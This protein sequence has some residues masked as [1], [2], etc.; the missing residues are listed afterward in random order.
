M[1]NFIA[2]EEIL[3]DNNKNNSKLNNDLSYD[4]IDNEIDMKL[5]Y[6]S[7]IEKFFQV[8]LATIQ[9]SDT[10]GI[11]E[12]I[13]S[14]LPESFRIFLLRPNA[15][16]VNEA[17]ESTERGFG[18]IL[19]IFR[20]DFQ[21]IF[22]GTL[23]CGSG[24]SARKNDDIGVFS[25]T[26]IC[27]RQHDSCPYSIQ[28]GESMGSLKNIGI[29]TRSACSCDYEFYKCL[30]KVNTL[31][32]TNIGTTYFNILRPQC[33]GFHYPI[34]ACEKYDRIQVLLDKLSTVNYYSNEA[35]YERV[36]T[37]YAWQGLLHH[38]AYQS[39]G[40]IAV[41]C[42]GATPI[43]D[44]IAGNTRRLP[45]EAWYPY[46]TKKSPAFEITSGHQAI[47]VIIA[48]FHNIAMDTLITGL[49][50]AAC[51]QLEIIKQNLKN[52]DLNFSDYCVVEKNEKDLLNKQINRI[53]EHSNE[54]Y[55]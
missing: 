26:D 33:F 50:N 13:V 38:A 2:S 10:N 43:A 7:R 48:C 55:K 5:T 27:C 32:S 1:V 37:Y 36:F 39:F 24:N 21:A 14:F 29:F 22:P 20:D 17:T 49:I 44:A 51:C 3:I 18:D 41:S 54:I 11:V 8:I 45:M 15:T 46:D 23:W 9:R 31:I 12:V 25:Q 4:Y 52:I 6:R 19:N 35:K 28:A 30:K 53:I 40:T 34:M 42:W 47:A 16:K